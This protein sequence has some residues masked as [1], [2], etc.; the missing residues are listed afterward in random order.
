[1]VEHS[2]PIQPIEKI[3][4]IEER[5]GRLKKDLEDRRTIWKIEERFVRLTNDLED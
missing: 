4:K 2:E 5:F 3:W 1:M